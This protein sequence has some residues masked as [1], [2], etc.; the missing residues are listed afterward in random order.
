MKH[1]LIFLSAIGLSVAL[2]ES[3]HGKAEDRK[4]TLR[5]TRDARELGVMDWFSSDPE[6]EAA[7]E[8]QKNVD[9]LL[10]ILQLADGLNSDSNF[11]VQVKIGYKTAKAAGNSAPERK[12]YLTEGNHDDSRALRG[13]ISAGA[14]GSYQINERRFK[15]I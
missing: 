5:G 12:L 1:I 3:T 8:R 10:K 15:N 6:K 2:T 13:R 9:N 14:H 4:L 7:K 11:G